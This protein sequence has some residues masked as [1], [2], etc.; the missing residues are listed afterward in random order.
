VKVFGSYPRFDF[1]S[2]ANEVMASG[3]SGVRV[4]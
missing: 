2:L 1:E 4:L 3:G